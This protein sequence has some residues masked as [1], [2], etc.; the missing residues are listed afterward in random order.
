[1]KKIILTLISLL[2]LI[3]SLS[4]SESAGK[5]IDT[6][7]SAID[8]YL[9]STCF[10]FIKLIKYIIETNTRSIIRRVSYGKHLDKSIL[11]FII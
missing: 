5:I 7:F 10:S 2:L 1:M 3:P 9:S 8:S 11:V 6:Y 4:F